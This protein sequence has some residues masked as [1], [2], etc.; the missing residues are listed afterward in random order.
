MGNEPPA[1]ET[2]GLVYDVTKYIHDH[3]GGAD[4]LIEAAGV[5]ASEAF[6]NAGHSEDASEIMAAYRVGTVKGAKKY[7]A[8]PHDA[9][10][11]RRS[12]VHLYVSAYPKMP[13]AWPRDQV[14]SSWYPCAVKRV[15]RFP[16]RGSRFATWHV[17]YHCP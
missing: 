10:R 16:V 2:G 5:D 7:S 12:L 11:N 9:S 17:E 4:V 6:D 3:P 1:N 14:E 8:K 13:H 15:C